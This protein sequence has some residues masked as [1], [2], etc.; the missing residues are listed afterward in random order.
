M[1]SKNNRVSTPVLVLAL[2]VLALAAVSCKSSGIAQLAPPA[3]ESLTLAICG[4]FEQSGYEQDDSGVFI[5]E[6]EDFVLFQKPV[7]IIRVDSEEYPFQG[8]MIREATLKKEHGAKR[9]YLVIMWWS[10]K[11]NKWVH[12]TGSDIPKINYGLQ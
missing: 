8:I 2:C 3:A 9:V 5:S 11:E 12:L 10:A 4:Y 7:H 6:R 1:S